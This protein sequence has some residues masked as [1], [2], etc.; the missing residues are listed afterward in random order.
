ML[1]GSVEFIQSYGITGNLRIIRSFSSNSV[2]VLVR[3]TAHK[4][5]LR[6]IIDAG[7]S[8]GHTGNKAA[9]HHVVQVYGIPCLLSDLGYLFP[10][11][12]SYLLS[13]KT[14]KIK[15]AISK[16]FS[17][18]LLSESLSGEALLHL[19][20]L[21]IFRMICSPRTA[22]LRKLPRIC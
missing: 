5:A 19:R 2:T 12:P 18:V 11:N 7:V 1:L 21:T 4:D 3:F 13:V 22:S 6:A 17:P 15:S 14:T 8:C 9:C 10:Q 16:D 20:K